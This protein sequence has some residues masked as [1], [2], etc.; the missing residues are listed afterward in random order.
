MRSNTLVMMSAI[1]LDLASIWA[2]RERRASASNALNGSLKALLAL[3]MT[4]RP[5]GLLLQTRPLEGQRNLAGECFKQ[6]AL[7]R[8]EQASPLHGLDDQY[9]QHLL[10]REQRQVLG[11]RSR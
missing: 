1:S 10:A 8:Q 4:A 7:L 3:V 11:R 9:A 6:V 5:F 2:D